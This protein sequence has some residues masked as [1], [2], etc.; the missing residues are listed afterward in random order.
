ML[1]DFSLGLGLDNSLKA[2][3]N[4]Y[5]LRSHLS[6]DINLDHTLRTGIDILERQ[7]D[8]NG[9]FTAPACDEFRPD[10]R[11]VDGQERIIESDNLKIYNYDIFIADD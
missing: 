7:I 1:S 10:C 5:T 8:F 6:T 4:D 9:D 2:T 11:L 3:S